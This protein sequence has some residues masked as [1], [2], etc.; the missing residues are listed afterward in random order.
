MW[1]ALSDFDGRLVFYFAVQPFFI[2]LPPLHK[3]AWPLFVLC[4]IWN[5]AMKAYQASV[6]GIAPAEFKAQLVMDYH[7]KFQLCQMFKSHISM[8]YQIPSGST[9]RSGLNIKH[10]CVHTCQGCGQ[11]ALGP[12][13]SLLCSSALSLCPSLLSS[14]VSTQVDRLL[15]ARLWPFVWSPHGRPSRDRP[16]VQVEPLLSAL[17]AG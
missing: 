4:D 7:S 3:N 5:W 10:A 15:L 12:Q 17:L 8:G 9:I 2:V 16:R 14:F 1:S 6:G 11:R 13:G